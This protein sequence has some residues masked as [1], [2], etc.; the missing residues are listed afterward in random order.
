MHLAKAAPVCQPVPVLIIAV[1]LVSSQYSI[2]LLIRSDV[3]TAEELE[4]QKRERNETEDSPCVASNDID[5]SHTSQHNSTVL[6]QSVTRAHTHTP[7]IHFLA[8]MRQGE[9]EAQLRMDCGPAHSSQLWVFSHPD[10]PSHTH[11]AQPTTSHLHP[12][13]QSHPPSPERIGT[14]TARG[15]RSE[16]QQPRS[17]TCADI[18]TKSI[19]VDFA[20]LAL[21][22]HSHSSPL[23]CSTGR[24]VDASRTHPTEEIRGRSPRSRRTRRATQLHWHPHIRYIPGNNQERTDPAGTYWVPNLSPR[25]KVE[26]GKSGKE[27]EGNKK[28]GKNMKGWR[29]QR[30]VLELCLLSK[31]MAHHRLRIGS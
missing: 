23:P 24:H 11:I 21:E 13:P 3:Q 20:H 14:P 10:I 5:T 31:P 26:I 27:G 2:H 4:R 22:A 12:L 28:R 8:P 30:E 6:S 9:A 1:D 18:H 15:V 19:L 25:R 16:D 7:C 17:I 29:E